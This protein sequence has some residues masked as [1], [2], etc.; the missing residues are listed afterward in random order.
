MNPPDGVE[1]IRSP[2]RSRRFPAAIFDFD[3]T[4]SLIREGWSGIMAQMGLAYLREQGLASGP[5]APWLHRLEQE[6]LLLSGK[7]SIFQMRRLAEMVAE[8]GGQPGNPEE[9]LAE[10]LRRLLALADARKQDLA[11]GRAS[12]ADWSVRGTHALLADLRRRGV[13]LYLASGT[14][15]RFVQEEARLLGLT[16]FFADRIY[17]PADN[18]PH[19][20]KGDVI[21]TVL[22]EQGIPGEQL[23]GFGDGYSETV[24]IRAVGGVMVGVASQE[25]G[26]LGVHAMKREMLITLGADV[27][28]PDYHPPH[29][30]AAWLFGE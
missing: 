10:F 7:P 12:P 9:Y 25:A 11:A 4:V 19:F 30:L 14:D 1:L 22:R 28:V 13:T 20:S 5:E 27:I 15:L 17:G 23:L 21:A 8:Q 24:E 2:L 29:P 6:V 26:I 16:E 3:G 18:T